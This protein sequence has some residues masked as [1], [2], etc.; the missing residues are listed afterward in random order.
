MTSGVQEEADMV[1][2]ADRRSTK[3][4]GV[5][6]VIVGAEVGILVAGC[7]VELEVVGR[8]VIAIGANGNELGKVVTGPNVGA[9]ELGEA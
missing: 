1:K 7:K 4:T 5:L 3:D 6:G 9:L 8:G 2:R